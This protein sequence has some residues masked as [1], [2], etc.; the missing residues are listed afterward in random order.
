MKEKTILVISDLHC[1]HRVGLTPPRWQKN[2]ANKEFLEV[3]KK[4]WKWYTKTLSAIGDIDLC[5][6]N[7]DAIDGAS[8]KT[9]GT[10][11]LVR[12]M[13]EQADMAWNSI[14]ETRAKE[15]RMTLGTPYHTGSYEDFEQQIARDLDCPISAHGFYDVRGLIFD[16]KHK[17]G[18]SSVPYGQHTAINKSALWNSINAEWKLQPK[19][20]IIVRSHLHF[21]AQSTGQL[22][23]QTAFVTAALQGS[24]SKFGARLCEKVVNVGMLV[25][26]VKNAKEWGWKSYLMDM[27][28]QAP[29][30]EKL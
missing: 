21:Y 11:L 8:S 4:I 15:Y 1:G 27:S 20:N 26:K 9:A 17:V 22:P 7:G 2:D 30:V 18:G 16:V 25:F 5:I 14:L 10:D 3:R 6:V 24:G 23:N 28:F 19:S 13:N 12:D 29:T